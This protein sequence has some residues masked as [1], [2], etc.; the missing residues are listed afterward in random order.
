[1]SLGK[2]IAPYLCALLLR[3]TGQYLHQL[4]WVCVIIQ[5]CA[6][7]IIQY[8]NCKGSGV[9]PLRSMLWECRLGGAAL[10]RLER[11]ARLSMRPKERLSRAG[12]KRAGAAV[13]LCQRRPSC[14]HPHLG[15]RPI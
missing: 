14:A 12:P 10:G 1:M 7:A 13:R 4:Q 6:I 3:F 11:D 9:L 2:S 15:F 8:D 5:C